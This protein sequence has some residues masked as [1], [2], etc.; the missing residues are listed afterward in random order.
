MKTYRLEEHFDCRS[1][2]AL[3]FCGTN[4]HDDVFKQTWIAKERILNVQ[5]CVNWVQTGLL[6]QLRR[7]VEMENGK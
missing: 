3:R 4:E 2:F 7:K 1:R 5:Q 6:L